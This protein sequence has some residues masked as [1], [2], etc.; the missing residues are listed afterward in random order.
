MKN[1]LIKSQI[2]RLDNWMCDPA[3]PRES[4]DHNLLTYKNW[5]DIL[6][7][8][9]FPRYLD[10][11]KRER[12]KEYKDDSNLFNYVD[13][14]SR[15]SKDQ[16]SFSNY[17]KLISEKLLKLPNSVELEELKGDM[18]DLLL[19]DLIL[20]SFSLERWS[21][22][23]K[24]L[25]GK[26]VK[27]I[28]VGNKN[29]NL[30]NYIS[31]FYSKYN[32]LEFFALK[33]IPEHSIIDIPYIYS[34]EI[35]YKKVSFFQSPYT[36]YYP[37]KDR[38]PTILKIDSFHKL[39]KK[40]ESISQAYNKKIIEFFQLIENHNCS[41]PEVTNKIDE[42]TLLFKMTNEAYKEF[43]SDTTFN[44]YKFVYFLRQL[45][46][47][48]DESPFEIIFDG[49]ELEKKLSFS[50]KGYINHF[51]IR[52]KMKLQEKLLYLQDII[53][54][55]YSGIVL[56]EIEN[57]TDLTTWLLTLKTNNQVSYELF[58]LLNEINKTDNIG[59]E[60]LKLALKLCSEK[61]T[62]L[63]TYITDILNSETKINTILDSLNKSNYSVAPSGANSLAFIGPDILMG[64]Y[65]QIEN[66]NI[67]IL[68]RLE[69][70][71]EYDIKNFWI[72]YKY[73]NF[74]LLNEVNKYLI[75]NY[76]EDMLSISATNKKKDFLV[77]HQFLQSYI[78]LF[79]T[80]KNLSKIH[81]GVVEK[82]L[83]RFSKKMLYSDKMNL[84]SSP[85]HGTTFMANYPQKA[86]GN[87]YNFSLPS[88]KNLSKIRSEHKLIS[89]VKPMREL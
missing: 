30:H 9:Y 3:L 8:K 64:Y 19:Q 28:C 4:Q 5:N 68:N 81:M 1:K 85:D 39:I 62:P 57:E 58:N 46:V 22:Y 17:Y 82:F 23:A 53:S 6:T 61:F 15:N 56:P 48:L 67:H 75:A 89:W 34:K 87:K 55:Y 47:E 33:S 36:N 79:E 7:I 63:N 86:V 41:S 31:K 25:P 16:F 26:S 72:L 88:L 76:H 77:E 71:N 84:K 13:Y 78:N 45:T 66:Y 65:S 42:I 2:L 21:Q 51:L 40:G 12:G 10:S 49:F 50:V 32:T 14:F 27:S 37:D 38:Y 11:I 73:R 24:N 69:V 18:K 59:S 20:I 35:K 74:N 52:K 60:R 83:F 70:M 54:L 44:E 29:E 43:L 80:Y